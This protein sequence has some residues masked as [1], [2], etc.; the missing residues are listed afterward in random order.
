MLTVLC[1]DIQL[2]VYR[3]LFERNYR[4]VREQYVNVFVTIVDKNE[5]DIYW[6]HYHNR[7]VRLE[8]WNI[9]GVRFGLRDDPIFYDHSDYK[10]NSPYELIISN[11]YTGYTVFE[12]MK[13]NKIV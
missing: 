8:E 11:I 7:F 5:G 10:R 2:I 12:V 13:S 6:N 9:R 4:D 3:Y 1:I